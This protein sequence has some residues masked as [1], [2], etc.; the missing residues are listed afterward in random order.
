MAFFC[1]RWFLLK[2]SLFGSKPS[3]R[4]QEELEKVIRGSE[5]FIVL[6]SE[7]S[8]NSGRIKKEVDWAKNE[9]EQGGCVQT[10]FPIK[11]VDKST[12]RDLNLEEF[13]G[14]EYPGDAGKDLFN[15]LSKWLVVFPRRRKKDW[16]I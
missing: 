3:S 9:Q 2:L 1:T 4:W 5:I 7:H 8:V 12:F 16:K 10:I 6:I 11:V 13:Y 15:E 14:M